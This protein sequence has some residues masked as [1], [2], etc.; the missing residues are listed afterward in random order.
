MKLSKKTLAYISLASAALMLSTT[1]CKK[2]DFRI[3]GDITD[4]AGKSLILEKA[5]FQGRWMPLDSTHID[6]NGKFTISHAA[7]A[8]SD[9]F[10][11]NL[12]GR[13]IYLPIDSTESIS[14]TANA[15]NFGGSYTVTGSE[16]AANLAKFEQALMTLH[17]NDSAARDNFK[18][19]VFNEYMCDARGSVLSYYILTKT[20][21]GEPLYNPSDRSDLKYYAAVA[22]A[23]D[24]Y[25]PNDPRTQ[26]LHQTAINSMQKNNQT[27]GKKLMVE[28]QEISVIDID[29]TDEND[30]HRKLS[31]VVG[32]GRKT[33]LIVAFM[34]ETESPGF[35]LSLSELYK[36]A[37]GNVEFYHVSVDDDRYAWR[38]A[39]K[40]LPWITVYDNG[41]VES[42]IFRKYNIG[43][44]PAFFIYDAQG[45]L[46][47]RAE[48]VPELQKLLG[49]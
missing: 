29:L 12:N 24:Q 23:F 9:I 48:S 15:A 38:D 25:R 44:L 33:V 13:Y 34:N 43:R 3:D 7:P 16:Q 17:F 20:I 4:G 5:D 26:M 41:G 2:H 22:T 40:N 1:A 28:A 6:Q 37:A 49:L 39:A 8:A 32:Q 27:I 14:I 19:E 31:D 47:D 46:T 30:R 11:L 45:Q 18:R 21:G 42:D 10:R 35:N 36:K